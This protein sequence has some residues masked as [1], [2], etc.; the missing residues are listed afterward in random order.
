M[1][2]RTEYCQGFLDS[3]SK[4]RWIIQ[5]EYGTKRYLELIGYAEQNDEETLK[6]EVYDA[7]YDLPPDAFNMQT[8]PEGYEAL[9]SFVEPAY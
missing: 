2:K 1:T 3:C 7:W 5:Q 6:T 8:K 9:L 4:F